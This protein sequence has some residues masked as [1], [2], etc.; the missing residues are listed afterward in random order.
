MSRVVVV[1]AGITGLAAAHRL[2]ELGRQVAVL[3]AS[4]RPGGHVH[5]ERHGPYL[6]E[7]GPDSILLAKPAGLRLLERL[8]LDVLRLP[9]APGDPRIVRD[10]RVLPLPDGFRLVAPTKLLPALRSPLLSWR[11][12]ARAAWER[13]VRPRASDEDESLGSFLRRRVGVEVAE[14]IAEPILASLFMG[15]PA[16]LGMEMAFPALRQTERTHGSLTRGLRAAAAAGRHGGPAFAALPQGLQGAIDALVRRLPAGAIETGVRVREIAPAR[17]SGWSVRTDATTQHADAVVLACPAPEASRLLSSIDPDAARA[18]AALPYASCATVH[19]AYARRAV[20]RPAG[21][22][23]FFV[24]ARERLLLL[25]CTDV[26]AKFPGRAPAD[27]VLLRAF[28]GGAQQPELL[29]LADDDLAGA[30]DGTL[31][32]LL[33][34][35][36]RPRLARVHRHRLAM[37]QYPVGWRRVLDDVRAR[38]AAHEGLLLAGSA[39]GAVGLPDCIASGEAAAEA[40]ASILAP[41]PEMAEVG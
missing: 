13:F 21:G 28:V 4:S 40:A 37:P 16:H 5:T 38:L 8:G 33:R 6:L 32:G 39:A 35:V 7:T 3:E 41:V 19:L 22:F 12:V 29:E 17:G 36:D 34:I 15:D 2:H 9:T 10:G 27:H 20:G 18:L 30:V 23:G 11:G 14:R 25:A 1:G 26:S 31:R 24:P